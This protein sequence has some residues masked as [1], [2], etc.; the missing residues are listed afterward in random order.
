MGEGPG[1]SD[2]CGS[3][4]SCG[5][6]GAAGEDISGGRGVCSR[7]CSQGSEYMYLGLS[8][9]SLGEKINI[10]IKKK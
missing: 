6:V 2:K 5:D 9:D 3:D 8:L 7:A 4:K 1:G 10:K